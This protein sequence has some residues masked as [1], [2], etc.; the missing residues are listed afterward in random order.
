VWI[1]LFRAAWDGDVPRVREL[2]A[3]GADVKERD[4]DGWMCYT[5]LQR[6]ALWKCSKN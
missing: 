6:T 3:R 1:E 4:A 2:V 5:S